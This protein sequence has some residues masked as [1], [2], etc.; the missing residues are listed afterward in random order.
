MLRH[1]RIY[2]GRKPWTR[3]HA[4]R[5]ASQ[6]FEHHAHHVLLAE[7]CQAIDDATVRLDRLNKLVTETAASWSMAPV[8]AAYKAMRGVAFMT[9]V[10]SVVEIGAHSLGAARP[11]AVPV[12]R[13]NVTIELGWD[14][15]I[16]VDSDIF[17]DALG[18]N[19]DVVLGR[20]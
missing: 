13:S 9:A 2:A 12:E 8:V 11:I 1:G 16:R 6:A 18:R 4:R 5:L 19:L 3:A 17:T 20:R 7:Y 14:R 15:P 10:T